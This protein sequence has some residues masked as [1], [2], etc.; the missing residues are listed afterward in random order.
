M[1]S[2]CWVFGLGVCLFVIVSASL[3]PLQE[4]V[5]RFAPSQIPS[6]SFVYLVLI[7]SFLS[8][9]FLTF[10]WA[11][12][13]TNSMRSLSLSLSRLLPAHP[14]P[15]S[16]TAHHIRTLH[17]PYTFCSTI[18]QHF[19]KSTPTTTILLL[20][21]NKLTPLRQR[22]LDKHRTPPLVPLL[23]RPHL[24]HLAPRLPQQH[25]P[26]PTR[27]RFF[28]PQAPPSALRGAQRILAGFLGAVERSLETGCDIQDFE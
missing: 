4:C 23:L 2:I 13:V 8:L 1:F 25:A 6:S 7:S 27:P 16:T 3:S 28:I 21:S 15:S 5:T 17:F 24:P 26:H 22:P 12:C 14:I 19:I 11:D 18:P 9:C 20:V 10:F